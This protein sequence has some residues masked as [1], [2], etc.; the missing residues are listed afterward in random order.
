M[1]DWFTVEK[2]DPETFAVSEYRHREETHAYLLTSGKEGILIDTGMGVE[3]IRNIT[4]RI[5]DA[6]IRVLTTHVHWDHIGS[7]GSFPSFSVHPL[8][9]GWVEDHF[10]LPLPAVIASLKDG[11]AAFPP[12]FD[13]DRYSLF[14]GSPS[15][16]HEDGDV[17]PFGT[18]RLKVIHTPGHS[19]GHCAFFEEERG[20]LFSGDLLY[21]GQI[22]AYYETTDPR[23]LLRSYEKLLSLPVKRILPGHHDLCLDN[24]IIREAHDTLRGLDGQGLLHHGSGVHVC[25]TFSFRF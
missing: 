11:A 13:P 9:K 6:G 2:I 21:K 15:F 4:D 5:S 1:K 23:A 8:E 22:D 10:P 18:R 16:L 20:Y 19:P 17:I 3:D 12:G 24:S 14:R 7:H 25:S